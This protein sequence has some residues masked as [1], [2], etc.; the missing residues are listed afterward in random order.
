M[1]AR[2]KSRPDYM[3]V[4]LPLGAMATIIWCLVS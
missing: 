2:Q 4:F 1:T 3:G